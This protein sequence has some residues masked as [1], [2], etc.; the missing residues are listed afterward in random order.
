MEYLSFL[1]WISMASSEHAVLPELVE[2]D[3]RP[4]KRGA[5]FSLKAVRASAESSKV[6]R[7][8]V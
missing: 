7:R 3:Q 5:L 1:G 8:L 4:V 6:R 2:V